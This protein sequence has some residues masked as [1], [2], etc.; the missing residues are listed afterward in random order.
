M[1]RKSSNRGRRVT[2][3]PRAGVAKPFFAPRGHLWLFAI[4]LAIAPILVYLPVWKAGFIWDDDAHLTRNPCVI[5]PLGLSDVWSTAQAF[6]YPLVLTTFWVLHKLVGLNPWP[7]HIFNV[8][9]HAGS[10]VLLWRIL[11]ELEIPGSWLGTAISFRCRRTGLGADVAGAFHHSGSCAVVLSEQTALAASAD[12]Y[13]SAVGNSFVAAH[14]L[15]AIAGNVGWFDRLVVRSREMGSSSILCRCI[16]CSLA[17]SSTRI[18]QRLFL[19]LLI[20]KRPFSVSREHGANCIG[21]GWVAKIKRLAGTWR[22]DA[23]HSDLRGA[24]HIDLA[25]KRELYRYQD[26]VENHQPEKSQLLD[27]GKQ[28]RERAA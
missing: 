12:L 27:G 16:L 10:A 9:L 11:Q 1:K 17:V 20:C 4:A 13:V 2:S 3:P 25:P 5:G 24:W 6:Y 22:V 28:S 26:T 18:F 19:P 21:F 7:Y 8:L 14:S 15:A 23:R